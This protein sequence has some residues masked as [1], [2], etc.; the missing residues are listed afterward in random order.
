MQPDPFAALRAKW[1]VAA[2]APLRTD[3][4]RVTRVTTGQ[5]ASKDAG[6]PDPYAVTWDE[7]GNVTHVTPAQEVWDQVPVTR[8]T[9][10]DPS[11]VTGR[12][13]PKTAESLSPSI[14]VTCVTRVTSF[15]RTER[16]RNN[17]DSP[18]A[19]HASVTEHDESAS[20]SEA[21]RRAFQCCVSEW[22]DA[23]P[24]PSSPG[25]CA[26]C[27]QVDVVGGVVVPFGTR[28]HT[29]LHPSCWKMWFQNRRRQAEAALRVLDLPV[30]AS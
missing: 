20:R 16:D 22:L 12:Q 23:N 18:L 19:E 30:F 15:Q 6:L 28:A 4:T 1:H 17:T 27:G 29:W 21:E 11:R 26:W 24:E 10:A 25:R 14:P 2:P 8:V 7:A 5:N 13:G 3:V 9:Q